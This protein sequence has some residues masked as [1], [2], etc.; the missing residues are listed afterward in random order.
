S[1]QTGL[2]D[3]APG[4]TS[5]AIAFQWHTKVK[6][7]LDLPLTYVVGLLAVDKKVFDALSEEDRKAFTDEFA[8]GF[9]RLDI[10]NRADNTAALAT[11]KLQGV[12][13]VVPNATDRAEWEKV[14]SDAYKQMT[15]AGVLTPAIKTA[16]EAAIADVR[17]ERKP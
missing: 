2:I 17:G 6:Y 15:S 5:G 11:L 1:L 14:G 9:D 13:V 3:T 7:L 8:A 12:Q 10:L 16:L 4:T